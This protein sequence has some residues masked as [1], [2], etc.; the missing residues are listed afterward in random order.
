MVFK[1]RN[2]KYILES[3]FLMLFCTATN[4]Y[5][6]N[7]YSSFYSIGSESLVGNP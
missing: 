7:S 3:L 6:I 4:E 5:D 1:F 2:I